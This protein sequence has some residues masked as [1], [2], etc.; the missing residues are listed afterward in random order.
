MDSTVRLSLLGTVHVT[1][2]GA[3]ISNFRSR[4][5]IALLGYLAVHGEPVPRERLADLFWPDQPEDRG[6]ANLSWVLNRVS[7][8]LPGC[9]EA[10]RHTVHFYCPDNYRLDVAWMRELAARSDAAAWAAAVDLYRGDLLE[11][12][13]LDGCAEFELWLVG[14]RERWRQLAADLFASLIAHRAQRGDYEDALSFARRLLA[15]QP[16]R[17]EAHRQVMELLAW[18]GQWSAAVA[19][20]ETCCRV[21]AEELGVEPGA[22]T[23]QLLEAIRQRK[24]PPLPEGRKALQTGIV[25]HLQMRYRLGAEMVRGG[26]GV[27]YRG[28]DTLLE[29]DVAIKVLSD[30]ALKDK[31]RA[32]MLSEA[33][34]AAGL[35]HPNIVSI[36]DAGEIGGTPAIVMELVDGEPLGSVGTLDLPKLHNWSDTIDVA[37]QICAALDHAHS[38]G[39]VHRDLKP[40]HVLV[41]REPLS[42]TGVTVKLIDFG[43]ARSMASRVTDEGKIVGTVYYLAPE[44]ALGQPYDGRAD[45]YALGAMLYELTTGRLPFLADDA[46][47]VISQHLHAP[48]VP[49]RARNADIPPAL[50]RL[51]VH[52][53]QKNQHDRPASAA[54]VL[55]Q[56]EAPGLLDGQA[57][58]GAKHSVLERIERGRMVGREC[59]MAHATV[60]WQAATAGQGHVLLIGG[61][62]GVGKTRLARELITQVQVLGGKV[63]VGAC[64]AEG[65]APYGAFAQML[66]HILTPNE[67]DSPALPEFVLARLCALAPA[68]RLQLPTGA[69]ASPEADQEPVDAQAEQYRLYETVALFFTA[70]SERAPLLLVVEDAHWADSGTV[71]L[72]RYLGRYMRHS[73]VMIV[74]THRDVEVEEARSLYE[75]F[76][77]FQRER[78]ATRLRLP[79]LDRKQ[80][81]EMLG[82]L[83]DQEITPEFLDGIYAETEG[84]PFFIE[85]VCNALVESGRLRFQDG[86]WHRPSMEDLG[87]PRS[88]RVAIQSRLRALPAEARETL[89]LAAVLGRKFEF[90][91]LVKASDLDKDGLIEA[92]EDAERAQLIKKVS[93]ERGG[94]FALV[95]SLIASTLVESTRTLQR[96]QLHRRVAAAMEASRPGDDS[97]LEALAYHYNEAGDEGRTLK[98]LTLA[99]DGAMA[100]Y[101]NE[102]AESYYR[103]ALGLATAEAERA[104]LL[105]EMGQALHR[106]GRFQEAM[107]TWGQGI[108]LYRALEDSDGIARLYARS[109]RAAAFADKPVEQLGLC[110]EGLA[111]VEGA[112]DSPGL[113]RLLDATARAHWSNPLPKEKGAFF[114]QQALEMA[115]RLGDVEAQAHAL[116]TLVGFVHPADVDDLAA[117][118]R[119]VE[120]AE[121]A[122]LL[123]AATRA[124][125]ILGIHCIRIP[126]KYRTGLEH[127]RR[128]VDLNRQMGDIAGQVFALARLV[129]NCMWCGVFEEVDSMLAQMRGL[130]S[131]LGERSSV[132]DDVL[133][134]ELEYLA[135]RGEWAECAQLARAGQASARER[136]DR[137]TL[138]FRRLWLGRVILESRWLQS[139]VFVGTWEEAEA[140]MTEASEINSS[141]GQPSQAWCAWLGLLFVAQGRLDKARRLLAK[142]RKNPREQPWPYDEAM[143]SILAAQLAAAEGHWM[144]SLSAFEAAVEAIDCLGWRWHQARWRLNWAEV[145][146]ARGEPAD[147]DRASELL[148]EAQTAFEEMGIPRFAAMAV[149]RLQKLGL[150]EKAA[151]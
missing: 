60:L 80:T 105:S 102:E 72:L 128:A 110:R 79:R 1:R 130:L 129:T 26:T 94:T 70:L 34:A 142:A 15:L 137:V 108:D 121:S 100:S 147:R 7:S 12:L 119:A 92:L 101:A 61:E 109:A 55:R 148:R 88:I 41:V 37:R 146:A 53:L 96:R 113:A 85:E 133:D 27:V 138:S 9:L 63:V 48:V 89:R 49:P 82:V 99:G 23:T 18:S 107:G 45:L 69:A 14:E 114:A 76:L 150:P 58:L 2:D 5:A 3:P 131:D 112:P 145:H 98:Y 40:Q 103:R 36:H 135:F 93:T 4:K 65:G 29:R 62:P 57:P 134:V 43:V 77:D 16:W 19:Q 52:L 71:S 87:V 78:L 144:E 25:D 132:E 39:I 54:E 139:G 21:L 6:R 28:Y 124:H 122:G 86:R 64:Y 35:N 56:L 47:G 67:W 136:G 10:D 20:Y 116:A 66:Q 117:L 84:N 151:T 31:S 106:Q 83:F 141:G 50:D 81:G 59:E 120:I 8:L 143:L 30:A 111:L 123:D 46:L 149:E 115:E 32:R 24:E 126:G 73:R 13:Y 95:H 118:T 11:G 127:L 140:A 17:E 44:L 22:E 68:L 97:Q 75:V 91:I 33:Q 104:H 74:A 90:D 125:G 42:E 51:I 38:H